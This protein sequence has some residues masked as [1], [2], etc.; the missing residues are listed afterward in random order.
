MKTLAVCFLVFFFGKAIGYLSDLHFCS[1]QILSNN[2]RPNNNLNG[3]LT[4]PL[5]SDR[6]LNYHGEIILGNPGKKFSV[7]FDTGS[8]DIWV[9][10]VHCESNACKNHNRFDPSLSISFNGYT[11]DKFSIKYGTGNLAGHI[12][13]DSLKI[14][15]VHIPNQL[16]GI[17]TEQADFFEKMKFDG[18][19]GLAYSSLS[20]SQKSPPMDKLLESGAI[21]KKAFS[22]W[23]DKLSENGK[24]G[25]ELIIGGHNEEKHDGKIRYAPVLTKKYWELGLSEVF[26]R[27]N[28]INTSSKSAII[29]T[30]TSLI[31]LPKSDA[32][33]INEAI[34]A[35]KLKSS[36]RLFKISCSTYDKE[37][38]YLTLGDVKLRISPENY[39]YQVK[40]GYCLSA[41]TI[42]PSNVSI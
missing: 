22:F 9:P 20:M 24:I 19:F 34:G 37:P 6:N 36:N 40:P 14:S 32:A 2:V 8:A 26:Y 12:V 38:V 39:I 29:D 35:E 15:D 16:F 21:K 10:S 28:K 41:F 33:S 3:T 31:A 30:G 42:N 13:S 17:S 23:F 4:I 5:I 7:V 25:G 1:N 18:V 27:G 11:K